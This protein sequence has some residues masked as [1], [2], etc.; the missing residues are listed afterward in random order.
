MMEVFVEQP[1]ASPWSANYDY[2]SK[3]T[4]ELLHVKT[5]TS[6]QPRLWQPLAISINRLFE[7]I[8]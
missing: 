6:S 7:S 2:L 5:V 4:F 8:T 3:K 1:L